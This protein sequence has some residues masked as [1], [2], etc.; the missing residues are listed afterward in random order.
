MIGEGG[1]QLHICIS[2]LRIWYVLHIVRIFLYLQCVLFADLL[3][4]LICSHVLPRSGWSYMLCTTCP[5]AQVI[6]YGSTWIAFSF[7][8]T[9]HFFASNVTLTSDAL[10]ACADSVLLPVNFVSGEAHSA[11]WPRWWDDVS[12]EAHSAWWPRWWDDA[13][14]Q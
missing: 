11:W 12:G 14:A 6:S 7:L 1:R 13:P 3:C 2:S 5:L 4:I 9:T 8:T 10:P